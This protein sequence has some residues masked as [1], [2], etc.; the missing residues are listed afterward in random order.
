VRTIQ[1]RVAFGKKDEAIEGPD[2]AALVIEVAAADAQADPAVSFMQGRL[3]ATGNT[4]LF[5]E[6]L[7]TGEIAAALDR[8]SRR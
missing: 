4:G 5:F 7:Q 6:R 1:Y 2:G 8:L 3:R